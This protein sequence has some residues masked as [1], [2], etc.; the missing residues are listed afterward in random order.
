MQ[1][2]QVWVGGGMFEMAEGRNI[3]VIPGGNF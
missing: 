3:N 2:L 1:T